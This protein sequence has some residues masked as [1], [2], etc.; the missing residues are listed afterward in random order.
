MGWRGNIPDGGEGGLEKRMVSER[1]DGFRIR[2]K[3]VIGWPRH[4][5]SGRL[6]FFLVAK[7][8]LEDLGVFVVSWVFE[9]TGLWNHFFLF[10]GRNVFFE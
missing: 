2:R 8:S 3:K 7:S 6:S 9:F 10:F 5:G 1:E 4:P